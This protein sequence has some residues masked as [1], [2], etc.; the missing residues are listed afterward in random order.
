MKK[1]KYIVG[2]LVIALILGGFINQTINTR[3]GNDH[4]QS[5][6]V[7][8][9]APEIVGTAPDGSQYRLSSLKGKMVLI[10]F[11]AA[12]CGPCRRENPHVVN[13]YKEFKN[14]QY[15][16]AEGFTVFSV[17]LDRN[18]AS[19]IKA[20]R[21]DNLMWK[22]HINDLTEQGSKSAADYNVSAIPTNFLVDGNGKIVAKNLRGNA[23][24][25]TLE[26]FVKLKPGQ[27]R[28]GTKIGNQAPEIKL[29]SPE[30]KTIALSSLRGKMV[31]VDFWAAWCGPCRRE[32]PNVVKAYHKYKD[33][34]FKNGDGF[35]VYGVSLDRNKQSWLNA[36]EKDKLVWDYH[37]SDLKYWQS[38]AAATYG[39]RSIPSNFLLDADGTIIAKNLRG[40]S[41]ENFLESQLQ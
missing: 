16:N 21:E 11:W 18:K 31:L 32:N 19:W 41:L 25:T 12:W 3:P 1:L 7:G 13:A 4:A 10:D 5:P 9:K 34:K 27:K 28:V 2:A 40:S 39:V 24:K 38:E 20:I 30:G 17:S 37:V 8:E 29:K 36:I 22:Y 23:L 33:K 15:K 14:K 26:K 35:T 6:R